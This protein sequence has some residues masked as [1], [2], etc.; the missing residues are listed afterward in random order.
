MKG[1]GGPPCPNF[2]ALFQEV[3]FWS[4]KRVYF[5]KNAN[6]LNFTQ[7]LSAR[8]K[9]WACIENVVQSCRNFA[10]AINANR[11]TAEL[12]WI[13]IL[14]ASSNLGKSVKKK[15]GCSKVSWACMFEVFFFMNEKHASCTV[16]ESLVK[17]AVIL[18]K[19]E[20]ESRAIVN[21]TNFRTFL[22][23][24]RT[25]FVDFRRDRRSRASSE[26]FKA[27]FRT[28]MLYSCTWSLIS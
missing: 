26:I 9:S 7:P 13:W 10:L 28:L 27:C 1:G 15:K 17:T 18:I 22:L 5:F 21:F 24:L 12:A 16:S 11:P 8:L 6:V 23:N 19:F 3:H 20:A 4:I 25:F 14:S 2:L